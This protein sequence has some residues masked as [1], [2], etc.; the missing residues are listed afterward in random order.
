MEIV[1]ENCKARLRI[2]D[3]KIPQGKGVVLSCPKCKNKL[4]LEDEGAGPAVELDSVA[5]ADRAERDYSY[6]DEEVA[7]DLYEE[8][9]KLALV[10]VDETH[11]DETLERAIEDVGFKYVSAQNTREAIGK[12]R[13]HHFDLVLLS[14]RFDGIE[15][16]QSPVLQYLNFLPMSIRRQIFFALIGDN[17]KTM[18]R[19][20]AFAMSANLVINWNDLGK[21]TSVLQYAISDN[22]KFYKVFMETMA[23]VGKG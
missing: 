11:H 14:D 6:D 3:E 15:L 20:T 10:M 23:E 18:S 8:G 22:E 2:P 21:I 9:A 5:E 16:G 4:L 19:M 17:F 1:C 7:L 12:M 13:L